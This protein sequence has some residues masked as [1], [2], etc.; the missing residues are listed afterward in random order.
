[1]PAPRPLGSNF[2][3]N[4][5]LP[6]NKS[7]LGIKIEFRLPVD[8]LIDRKALLTESSVKHFLIYHVRDCFRIN[9]SPSWRRLCRGPVR[10][11][12][13]PCNTTNFL[14]KLFQQLNRSMS[15]VPTLSLESSVEV[16]IVSIL[17]VNAAPSFRNLPF[18]S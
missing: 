15:A 5:G 16:I 12:G 9:R 6:P 4:D 17:L 14:T 10:A 13:L 2:H 7:F 1:M 3:R 11:H 18:L 8:K